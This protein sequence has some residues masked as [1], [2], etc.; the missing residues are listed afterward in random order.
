MS[1][2]KIFVMSIMMFHSQNLNELQALDMVKNMILLKHWVKAQP[3]THIM[4]EKTTKKKRKRK[5]AYLSALVENKWL[6]QVECLLEIKIHQALD[7]TMWE[8]KALQIFVSLWE[9]E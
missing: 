7:N 6:S 8:E 9:L 5:K 2:E 4:L 3:Q 1:Q